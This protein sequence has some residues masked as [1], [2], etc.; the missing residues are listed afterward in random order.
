MR[1]L[2]EIESAVLGLPPAERARFVQW[3]DD[4]RP[5]LLPADSNDAAEIAQ[6]HRLEVLRRRD[7]LLSNPGLAQ[8]FEQNYFNRLRQKVADVHAG[9]APAGLIVI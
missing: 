4:N 9:K 2:A 1:S 5:Q 8:G 3:L 6:V 7:E